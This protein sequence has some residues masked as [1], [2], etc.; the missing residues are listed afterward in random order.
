MDRRYGKSEEKTSIF[1][2][3]DDKPSKNLLAT[4]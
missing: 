2:R 3:R 4:S 1:E